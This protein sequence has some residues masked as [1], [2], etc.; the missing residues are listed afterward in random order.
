MQVCSA[1]K[2]QGMLA[3]RWRWFARIAMNNSK[4]VPADLRES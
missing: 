3:V 4:D 1:S 2:I